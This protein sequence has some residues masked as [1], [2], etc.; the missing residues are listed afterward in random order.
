[1]KSRGPVVLYNVQANSTK[2]IDVGVVN[3]GPKKNLRWH[4]G[5]LFGQKY[6]N[7]KETAFIRSLSGSS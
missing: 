5:I 4:H 7:G 6:L 3:L 1:M 2:L